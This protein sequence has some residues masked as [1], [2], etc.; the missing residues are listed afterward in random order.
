MSSQ[1]EDINMDFFF[2]LYRVRVER[3]VTQVSLG[4]GGVNPG[5]FTPSTQRDSYMY[6][7]QYNL[8]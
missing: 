8:E 2:L 5:K 7:L 3:T 6:A 1:V 4:K